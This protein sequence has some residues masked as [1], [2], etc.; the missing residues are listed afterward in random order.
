MREELAVVLSC[1]LTCP[2]YRPPDANANTPRPCISS[3]SNSPSYSHPL[4][5]SSWPRPCFMPLTTPP[6]YTLPC[7]RFRICI[8]PALRHIRLRAPTC[9]TVL[10]VEERDAHHPRHG[11]ASCQT[12]LTW[13]GGSAEAA[14][15]FCGRAAAVFPFSRLAAARPSA[16]PA[17]L[18]SCRPCPAGGAASGAADALLGDIDSDL[19]EP[20]EGE[21]H[22]L[23]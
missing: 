12:K 5:Y 3:T 7:F 18:P 11:M 9:I 23:T 20:L 10:S 16:R 6:R 19:R 14:T 2:W 1:K 21:R 4:L 13:M 17:M 22:L 8:P 15:A